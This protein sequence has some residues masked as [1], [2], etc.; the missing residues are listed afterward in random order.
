MFRGSLT[1]AKLFGIPVRIHWTFL[2]LLAWVIYDGGTQGGSLAAGLAAAALT[3]AIF[4]CVL[5][6]EFGHILVA[7]AFGVGTRDVTL[8]PIGGVA[9]LD[10]IPDRPTEELAIA[11][12]GPAVNVVIVALLVPFLLVAVP[13]GFSVDSAEKAGPL[14][15]FL[16]KVATINIFLVLFNALPAFPMDGGRVLRA[17]LAL[18][19]DHVKATTVAAA[20]GQLLAIGL[21]VL[22]VVTKQPLL[23]I[24]ALFVFN[25]ARSEAASAK[26][27]RV[28]SVYPVAVAMR[29][30]YRLLAANDTLEA[31][32]RAFEEAGPEELLVTQDGTAESP[33]VGSVRKADVEAAV[34]RRGGAASIASV[35]QPRPP[36]VADLSPLDAAFRL[37]QQG[38]W[39]VLPVVH[40]QVLVGTLSIDSMVEAMRASAPPR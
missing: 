12:A 18:M 24:L 38:R 8:L 29:R 7:R 16:A 31:A 30:R 15:G 14:V 3:I 1:I 9:T 17:V 10:R 33:L 22:A 6:H 21:G 25:G 37:L 35:L 34:R 2:L 5:A 4:A 36:V 13:G 23:V 26:V 40:G 28:L 39:K 11:I 20:I 27:R 32:A 19:M